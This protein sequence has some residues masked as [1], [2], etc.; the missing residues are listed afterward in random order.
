MRRALELG[1][2]AGFVSTFLREGPVV[3]ADVGRAVWAE[4]RWRSSGLALALRERP[5]RQPVDDHPLVEPLTEKER[6]VLQFLTTHLSAI[7]IARQM[8]VCVNTLRTHIK[9][10]YRKLGVNT[11]SQAVRR[12]EAL[13]LVTGQGRRPEAAA[14]RAAAHFVRLSPPGRRSNP[15]PDRRLTTSW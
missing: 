2:T 1:V 6:Q 9:G 13:G 14:P 8:F 12:A 11:R 4:Q 5:E 15:G 10:I 7:E 3:G